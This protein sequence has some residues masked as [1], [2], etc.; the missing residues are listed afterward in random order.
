MNKGVG[1]PIQGETSTEIRHDGQHKRNKEREGLIGVPRGGSGLR[2]EGNTEARHL[3]RDDNEH[4]PRSARHHNTT[5]EGAEDKVPA[6]EEDV[7]GK[8][9]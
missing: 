9:N 4:G 5:L 3:S 1:R 2:G 8:G 6:R 7:V